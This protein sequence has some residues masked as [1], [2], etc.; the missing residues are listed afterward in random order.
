MCATEISGCPNYPYIRINIY[1]NI[2]LSS[3]S[4]SSI[5]K[6]ILFAY[7]ERPNHTSSDVGLCKSKLRFSQMSKQIF[8]YHKKP[9]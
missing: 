3:P 1:V 4:G 9:S 2:M 8:S 7:P 6:I 5:S